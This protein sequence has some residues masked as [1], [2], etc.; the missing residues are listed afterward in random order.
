MA[1]QDKLNACATIL[2][3]IDAIFH[4]HPRTLEDMSGIQDCHIVLSSDWRVFSC[5]DGTHWSIGRVLFFLGTRSREL[6]DHTQADYFA[7]ILF[8]VESIESVPR[9]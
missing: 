6:R 8:I 2:T 3:Q 4:P 1:T 5:D 9:E 7:R